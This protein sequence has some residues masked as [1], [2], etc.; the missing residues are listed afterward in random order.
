[1]KET[2]GGGKRRKIINGNKSGGINE[3][4]ERQERWNK[5]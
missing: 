3:W 1:M 4:K 5:L 2:H